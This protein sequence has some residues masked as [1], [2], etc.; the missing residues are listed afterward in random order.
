MTMVEQLAKFAELRVN[1]AL[2]DEEFAELK[3]KVI[4]S[5]GDHCRIKVRRP[6]DLQDCLRRY[7]IF[8]NGK[9]VG[10]IGPRGVLNLDV[11]LRSWP[12]PGLR[13]TRLS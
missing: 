3:A 1:G 10:A 8:I 2:T 7:K 13:D 6:F 9:E 11:P 12:A 5:A 4:Q